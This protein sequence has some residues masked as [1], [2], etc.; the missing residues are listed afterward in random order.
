LGAESEEL[1]RRE[2]AG[3][4][5]VLSGEAPGGLAEADV[6]FG[7]PD[8]ETIIA[9][10]RLRW[11]HLTSAGYTRYDRDDLRDALRARGAALTNSSHV[12]DEPCA[13]HAAAMM[14]S[15]ARQLPQALDMQRTDRGWR[16]GPLRARSFLLDRGQTVLLLG[17]GA[18][19]QRLA[20]LLAPYGMRLIAV[21]RSPQGGEG[22]EIIGEA[23]L[24]RVLPQADHV[25][26]LLPESPSTVGY[27]SAERLAKMKPGAYFYNIG[28]GATV[29]Q[30]A[31]IA[32]LEQEKLAAAYLDVTTPEPLPPDDPLWTAPNCFMTPH[33]AGG[34]IG[35]QRRLVEH[36]VTNLRAF[37]Q[38]ADLRDRV[39]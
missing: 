18:I 7:Q 16:S 5:L 15:F 33:S 11:A 36:F 24:D 9:S 19:G 38:G 1:L 17:F 27:V 28:R 10:A 39:V 35:E 12:Y 34:H 6:A 14:L 3:H 20:Q 13:Q 8:P 30:A 29:D 31:L 21:R 2:T 25:V 26:N 23:E 22:V 37:E 4:R 32:S